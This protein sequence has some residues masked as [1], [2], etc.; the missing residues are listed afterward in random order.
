MGTFTEQE[1]S[2]VV[3][4]SEE[5]TQADT[6]AATELQVIEEEMT[7]SPALVGS[8]PSNPGSIPDAV[9]PSNLDDMTFGFD[10]NKLTGDQWGQFIEED[11]LPY[12]PSGNMQGVRD[13]NGNV[14]PNSCMPS[15]IKMLLADNGIA[16]SDQEIM[17]DIGYNPAA[18]M[19]Q[20]GLPSAKF[21]QNMT[22]SDL[23]NVATPNRPV[24]GLLKLGQAPGSNFDGHAV[25]VDGIGETDDGMKM[26][27]I[28]DPYYNP[29][30]TYRISLAQFEKVWTH[31]GIIY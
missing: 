14:L 13:L 2:N 10:M 6:Q 28:R 3:N 24:I 30:A 9:S 5:I 26:V 31:T 16:A 8:E 22:V 7:T 12:F 20:L 18:G 21:A 17:S 23:E 19:Q 29:P 25:L 4:I 1:G 27:L 15:S 11:G